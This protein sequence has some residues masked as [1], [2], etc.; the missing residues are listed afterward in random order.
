MPVE[1]LIRGGGAVLAF[2]TNAIVGFSRERK[3]TL[4]AFL[5][6]CNDAER[7]RLDDAS[8]LAIGIVVPAL[9]RMEALHDLRVSRGEQPFDEQT[10][11]DGLRNKAE[12]HPFDEDSAIR[13][14]GV[15]HGWFP[16]DD[17][18][19]AAKRER[20]RALMGQSPADAPA[21]IDWAIA[22]Q[23]EA[24][25]WVLVTADVRAEFK[26]VS[27]KMTKVDLRE[28]LDELLRERGLIGSA[29]TRT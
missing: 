1:E 16:S 2:D 11:K 27:R 12:V 25:G 29:T 23:A 22:A 8:P 18:W 21:T 4:R 7:L 28:L 14:S 20:L 5:Q 9:A 24:E 17:A 15:L 19:Q 3:V 6:M 10:V 26:H 13:A